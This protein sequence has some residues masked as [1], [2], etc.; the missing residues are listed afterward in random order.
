METVGL[1]DWIVMP[2]GFE[3]ADLWPGE[4]HLGEVLLPLLGLGIEREAEELHRSS[5]NGS[6]RHLLVILFEQRNFATAVATPRGPEIDN[7][8]LATIVTQTNNLSQ[9]VGCGEVGRKG[10]ELNL[11]QILW[12]IG[13]QSID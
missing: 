10:I 9:G 2:L 11:R 3:G 8:I 6:I 13:S 5:L 1:G 7:D 4:L 12:M